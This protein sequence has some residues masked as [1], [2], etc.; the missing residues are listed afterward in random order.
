MPP[1]SWET[2]V[3]GG[4]PAGSTTATILAQ[5]GHRVLLLERE[6]SRRFRI[7]ESLMPATYWSFQRL[8]VLEKLARAGFVPK[9]SVQ[10]FPG[11]G[12]GSTPFYFSQT[13]PGPSSA[14]WQVNRADFDALLLEHATEQGVEVRQG[15]EVEEVL[16]EGRRAVGV[17]VRGPQGG[18]EVIEAPV[19]ADATGQ[20]ALLASRLHLRRYDDELRNMAL[21]TRYEGAWRGPGLDEGATLVIHTRQEKS[22]FWYIPLPND[23]VSVGVVGHV[24]HLIKGRSSDPT[25]VYDEEEKACPPLLERVRQGRRIWPIQVRRDYSYISRAVAG[26]G[27][28]LVGD[29]FGF[30]DP[31][32][33]SGVL[34]AFKGGEMAADS[35]HAALQAGDPSA[36]RLGRHGA[37]FIAG[38]EALR[39]LVYA[40]YDPEFSFS[41]F[42]KRH[43]ASKDDITH[44]L[45]GNVFRRSCTGVLE[46]LDADSPLP[47]YRPLEL[48]AEGR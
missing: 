6:P 40:Y 47:H 34:L 9:H 48:A 28:V 38:M 21:F 44:L 19:I 27:W 13:E 39:R 22:W 24:D 4:G 7:G 16:F 1:K 37:E 31:I 10:F 35:I 43:P 5:H 46:I 42:L 17:K 33:S 30:L 2:I 25:V 15:V 45:I 36:A 26:D 14:T 41:R 32:Y 3:I 12:K 18:S 20:S 11:S 8:G 23:T 29:A